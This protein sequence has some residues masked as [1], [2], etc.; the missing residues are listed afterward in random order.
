MKA[1]LPPSRLVLLGHPVSHSL[2]PQMHNAALRAAG[3]EQHYQSVDVEITQLDKLLKTLAAENGAGN[4]TVPHKEA[5]FA[6]CQSSTPVAERAGAVNTF[7]FENSRLVGHNTDVG[8]AKKTIEALVPRGLA[9]KKCAVIGAGGSAA[10]V[11][12]ALEQLQAMEIAVHSRSAGRAMQLA[13][14]V[15]VRATECDSVHEAIHGASLVV[16]ATPVGLTGSEVPFDVSLLAADAAVFDLTYRARTSGEGLTI[17][18]PLV[19]AAMERGLSA[20]SGLGMLVEQGALAFECW[21]GVDAS[22][23]VMAAA[24]GLELSAR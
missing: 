2:S 11:L 15:S 14:R 7:W 8:G 24:V 19:A 10:A 1:K 13:K 18:T 16:N 21:F 17:E 6:R 3:L 4:V 22:R 12:L 20:R 23:E 9:G 5:V